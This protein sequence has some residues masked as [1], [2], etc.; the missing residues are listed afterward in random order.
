MARPHIFNR[1]YFIQKGFQ[2]KF[3]I[4][5]ILT[6]CTVVGVSIWFLYRQLQSAVVSHLYRTHIKVERVGD[7]LV[8][9]MFSTN[10]YAVLSIVSGVLVISL[11]VFMGINRTFGR[12]DK[13]VEAMAQGDFSQ[14]YKRG[15][16]FTEVGDLRFLLEQARTKNQTRFLQLEAVLGELEQGVRHQDDEMI[17]KGKAQLDLILSEITL[18]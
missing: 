2:G 1:R 3:I 14:P 4:L 12:I 10:F 7:F 6:V 13:A 15:Y 8:D 18:T 11:L 5:Y 9:L 17:K 16:A